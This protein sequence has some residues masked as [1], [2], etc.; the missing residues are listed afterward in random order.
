MKA[1]IL[2]LAVCLVLPAAPAIAGNGPATGVGWNPSGAV[3]HP[4]AIKGLA[5]SLALP[6]PIVSSIDMDRGKALASSAS[7]KRHVSW[8]GRIARKILR[9][10]IRGGRP[11]D[12]PIA[13]AGGLPALLLLG[14]A[15][16]AAV[17]LRRA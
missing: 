17:R 15:F 5:V 2:A 7:A 10:A 6:G 13:L 12:A 4:S 11:H 8:W 16:G 3:S 9:L 1:L 14:G